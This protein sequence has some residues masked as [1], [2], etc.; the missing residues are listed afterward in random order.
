M[1][2][3]KSATNGINPEW[4]TAKEA[5]EINQIDLIKK[6]NTKLERMNLEKEGR[7]ENRHAKQSNKYYL[8]PTIS[9]NSSSMLRCIYLW[10]SYVKGSWWVYKSRNTNIK[11]RSETV[12]GYSNYLSSQTYLFARRRL[13][14][15]E[16]QKQMKQ[17]K[18]SRLFTLQNSKISSCHLHGSTAIP[19]LKPDK[20]YSDEA[21][22]QSHVISSIYRTPKLPTEAKL[23]IYNW[24]RWPIVMQLTE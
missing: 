18:A 17:M 19:S 21:Q 11:D 14:T 23:Q 2:I 20:T 22:A 6:K 8:M 12:I 1:E 10:K 9:R 13:K 3:Q 16:K 24:S 5:S 4:Y 7:K 15:K